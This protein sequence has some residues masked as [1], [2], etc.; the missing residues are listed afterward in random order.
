MGAGASASGA[1]VKGCSRSSAPQATLVATGTTTVVDVVEGGVQW[2]AGIVDREKQEK[3][4]IAARFEEKCT[5]VTELHKEMASLRAELETARRAQVAG[6]ESR[7]TSACVSPAAGNSGGGAQASAEPA[8]GKASSSPSNTGRPDEQKPVGGSGGLM[9]RRGMK[10]G[11]DTSAQNRRA[12][13]NNQ[14]GGG[15][16]VLK[17]VVSPVQEK[18]SEEAAAMAAEGSQEMAVGHRG[19]NYVEEPMSALLRRRA[20]D[21]SVGGANKEKAPAPKEEEPKVILMEPGAS[22]KNLQVA[23]QKVFSLFEDC[24]ASPK[25]IL[26]RGQFP[27]SKGMGGSGGTG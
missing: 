13:A 2:L 11:I 12:A 17:E 5:E 8:V 23:P 16:G 4:W 21:W 9:A 7:T 14:G 1:S 6:Y 26:K 22:V 27:D 19:S 25:R 18:P 10:L 24:P 20:E 15:G 3:E